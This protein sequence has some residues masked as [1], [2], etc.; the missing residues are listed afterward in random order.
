MANKKDVF[1]AFY[2]GLFVAIQA[3]Q[4]AAVADQVL[5][6]VDHSEAIELLDSEAGANFRHLVEIDREN[7]VVTG[8]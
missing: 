5:I 3:L 1:N 7:G 8:A 2:E 4:H 6:A